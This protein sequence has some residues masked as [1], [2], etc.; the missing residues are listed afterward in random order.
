LQLVDQSS[1]CSLHGKHR[2][3]DSIGIAFAFKL[4]LQSLE[5][6][7]S[8]R[9]MSSAAGHFDGQKRFAARL[10]GIRILPIQ[11]GPLIKI[12]GWRCVELDHEEPLAI[13]YG[14]HI[15]AC[16]P[17]GAVIEVTQSTDCQPACE[18][19]GTKRHSPRLQAGLRSSNEPINVVAM[20]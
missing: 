5:H 20:L 3:L 16:M 9:R 10:E 15:M 17:C 1:C 19:A 2:K 6:C 18:R 7:P 13:G 8:L 14:G 4:L 12:E 11:G